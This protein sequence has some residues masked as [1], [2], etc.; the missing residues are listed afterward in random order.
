[1][2]LFQMFDGTG[3]GCEALDR[4]VIFDTDWHHLAGSYDGTAFRLY[5]D[6]QLVQETLCAITPANTDHPVTIGFANGPWGDSDNSPFDGFIDDVRIYNRTLSDC[7]I[8]ALAA[9]PC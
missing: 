2:I 5:F 9:D 8:A 4:S 1:M 7:E 6:G 3:K